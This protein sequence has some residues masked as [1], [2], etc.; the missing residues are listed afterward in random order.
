[1]CGHVREFVRYVDTE[2]GGYLADTVGRCNREVNCG[3][4]YTPKQ[5]FADNKIS[6][7]GNDHRL[8]PKRV[9]LPERAPK[10]VSTIPFEMFRKSLTV[11]AE[12]N[13]VR[14]LHSL[15][16]ADITS[17]LIKRF[18]IGT[19]NHWEGA[20]I[21]WQI[22]FKGR[23]RSG[24]I[25]LYDA[26]TGK[27][28]KEAQPDGSKRSK[29]TWA[30]SVLQRQGMIQDFNLRQ[31]LFGEHQLTD[32]TKPVAIVESEKTAII[33]S[34]YLPEYIWLA[35]GSLTNLTA[36]KCR[37]L[38]G[39]KIVLFP[40]LKCFD[41]WR[42]RAKQI[43][44]QLDCHITV[45]DLLERRAS[46]ADKERGL[47]LADY[48]TRFSPSITTSEREEALYAEYVERAAI[49]EYDEGLERAEAE[50][51]AW[52]E[53]IGAPDETLPDEIYIPASVLNTIEAITRCIEAQR[54]EKAA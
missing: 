23:I 40:D 8:Q 30:H 34:C 4:H 35:C 5:Y 24:K 3:Y 32:Q 25:M 12:N 1:V 6:S 11:Y 13:F 14:Y 37:T 53:L 54:I 52:Y 26:A 2:R 36:D 47:D 18:Y 22:D 49:I 51:L 43:Q 38:A 45:S 19:S 20:T 21:F 44:A 31:C 42:N 10:P 17:E 29:I 28:V 15:F 48:L 50:R 16:D 9:M 27:R 33:A 46:E 41:K 39:R 7:Q